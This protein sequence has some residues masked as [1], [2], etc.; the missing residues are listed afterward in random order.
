MSADRWN[1]IDYTKVS[2][3]A[4]IIYRNAF[5]LHDQARRKDYLKEVQENRAVIHAGALMP[6]EI[7][8]Q[9]MVRTGWRMKTGAEDM[10][11]EEFDM[12]VNSY[13]TETLFDTIGRRFAVYGYKMP[14]LVF[15]NVNSRTNVIPVRENELGVALVSGFSVNICNMV[16]SN[17]LDPFAC[18]KKVLDSERYRKV[19]ERLCS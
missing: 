5:M 8:A 2:S 13:N 4:N 16:L 7:V 3:K 1:E 9:Y 15:W 19:E 11:L 14:K 12:A 18:L 6:H 17:E 10:T